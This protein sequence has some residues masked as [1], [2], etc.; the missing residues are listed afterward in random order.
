[1]DNNTMTIIKK[2]GMYLLVIA[3][4]GGAVFGLA[5]LS[6][7]KAAAPSG[8]QTINA[9]SNTAWSRGKLDAK[10]T[11]VEYADFQC[12]ACRAYQPLVSELYREYGDRV[13]FEYRH[14]PL[15]SIHQ[16]AEEAAMAA[17]AAGEQGKFWEMTD[18]LFAEQAEWSPLGS[19]EEVFVEYAGKLGLDTARF[20]ADLKSKDLLEKI[21]ASAKEGTAAGIN[22]TPSFFLNGSRIQP[23]NYDEFKGAVEQALQ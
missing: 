3:L 4:L 2:S 12:P 11:V 7:N 5:K 22:S 16:N 20:S 21:R 17:E 23:K 10:V 8:A 15:N 14:F 13:R 6:E 18:M 19:P 1:M 9:V